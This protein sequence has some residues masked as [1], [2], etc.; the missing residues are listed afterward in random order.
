MTRIKSIS[1]KTREEFDAA[2]NLAAQIQT[3]IRTITAKRDKL[4]QR[5]QGLFSEGL[6]IREA[7]LKAL[8]ALAE[9]YAET[10]REELLPSKAKSAHTELAAFGFRLGNPT[11]SLLN[12]KWSWES[13]V[14]K[15]KLLGKA[16]FVRTVEEADKDAI[17]AADLTDDER[18]AFG[19]K[20][21]QSETFFIEPK[22][23]G[24]ETIKAEGAA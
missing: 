16:A 6:K 15:L 23:A 12:K 10:H 11:L 13:V 21:T 14:E 1:Y 9:K 8:V 5:A 2:V 17:K 24:G 19:V 3:E 22:V 18:A 4:I 7:Q 20:I